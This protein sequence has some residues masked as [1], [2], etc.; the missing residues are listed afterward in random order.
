MIY[1]CKFLYC[2]N[3][4]RRFSVTVYEVTNCNQINKNQR[5][6]LSSRKVLA[7]WEHRY[8]EANLTG[9]LRAWNNRKERASVKE[10]SLQ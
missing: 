6:P 1:F 2:E 4:K 9:N 7:V 3:G 5:A 10:H 8:P